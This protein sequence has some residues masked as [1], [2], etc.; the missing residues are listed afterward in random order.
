MSTAKIAFL[1]DF[2]RLAGLDV[3]SESL[4]RL[5]QKPI[6][7]GSIAEQN[8]VEVVKCL[9]VLMNTDVSDNKPPCTQGRALTADW[10]HGSP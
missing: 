2:V 9:R 6:E 8:V 3:L 7:G 5:L 10:F 1:H 4:H